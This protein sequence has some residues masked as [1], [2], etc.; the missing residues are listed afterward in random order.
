[1]GRASSIRR[2]PVEVQQIVDQLIR[3][4]RTIM[5]ITEH[6]KT[7]DEDVSKS[8]VG[9]YV[10]NAREQMLD[11]RAAQELASQWTAQANEN[12]R[13]DVSRMVTEMLKM[14]AWRVTTQ[15]KRDDDGDVKIKPADLMLMSKAMESLEST[16]R[17][18]LERETATRKLALEEAAS[19]V[20][21]EGKKLGLTADAIERMTKAIGLL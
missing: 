20:T 21:G 5:E 7:L 18:S 3:Q 17:K 4:G 12:P 2:L 13:G 11:Y 14:V 19:K 10:K 8:A 6:L 9:R 15:I 1:M 16:T